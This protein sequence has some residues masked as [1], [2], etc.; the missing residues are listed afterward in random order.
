MESRFQD[1]GALSIPEYTIINKKSKEEQVM[2][3]KT[4]L[5]KS[6]VKPLGILVLLLA[7]S[8][9]GFT[10]EIEVLDEKGEPITQN[11]K[12]E[13]VPDEIIVNF[14]PQ[15]IIIP[16]GQI[17][18]D[19]G[20]ITIHPQVSALIN[21]NGIIKVKKVI[22][23]F[24]QADTVRTLESG[25]IVQVQ[26]L[27]QVFVLSFPDVVDIPEMVNRFRGSPRVIYAQPNYIYRIEATP[28][29][30]EYW[31]QWALEQSSDEDIDAETAWDYQTGSYSIRVGIFDTGIDYGHDDLGNAFGSG[32]KVAGG[33]DWV[34]NDS[35]P[36]DD[37]NHG[38]HVAGIAGALTNNTQN[39]NYIGIAGVAGGWGYERSANTGNKGVQL[40][41]MKIADSGGSI[42]T[43]TA[44]D[45]I[46][47]GADPDGYGIHILNNSWGGYGYD[48]TLRSAVNYAARMNRVFVAAKGNDDTD[49]Y[50][51]PSDYDGSWV[52]S[53]GA[54]NELGDRAQ[55]PDWGWGYG[56]GS[57]YGNGIDVVAPG[58]RIYSTI[59]N[60]SY[61]EYSGTS[62]ATPH[63]S[64]LAALILSENSSLHPEDVQ[65]IIRTSAE[66]NNSSTFPG[67]DD[68]LGAGRINAGDALEMLNAPWTLNH[69]TASGGTSVSNTG[70]YTAIFYN[71]GGGLST[72]IYFVKRY[73]VR[74][75]V[76]LSGDYVEGPY[77]WGRGVNET[78]GW[79]AANPNYQVGYCKVAS[80][81]STSAEL[82]SFVYE[83]W[84]VSG[85]YLGWY[86]T[87][88]SNVT[89]DDLVK[90][91]QC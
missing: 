16:Q 30:P 25:K 66:D 73:D 53:V 6:M 54:T 83:V 35:D 10:Q 71:T 82:Q 11:P 21:A 1:S 47:E 34:N 7:L 51:Y 20:E 18:A 90:N 79:S 39:G 62:M 32:W 65:G 8:G 72:G 2:D 87:T 52:I 61:T 38:T 78:V 50:H 26:D 81:T 24:T 9:Y 46:V 74:K 36:G 69:Y 33:Y 5:F 37:H 68:Y 15:T 19:V 40:F 17:E 28:N 29:D 64:G 88:P 56:R 75:T 22:R 63:V 13:Y 55:Y 14:A 27:S 45:A 31:R 23:F 3:F 77:V 84:D 48:E 43:S 89:F 70:T 86:P 67:Y 4:N 85:Q 60:Q 44:A 57:N 49:A 58:T 42:S 91:L 59:R 41:A 12:A 80:S 76:S